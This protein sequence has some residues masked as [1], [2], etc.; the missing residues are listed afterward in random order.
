MGSTERPETAVTNYQST[1][2]NIPQER[3]TEKS[4]RNDPSSNAYFESTVT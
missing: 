1:L 3:R 2:P 4:F